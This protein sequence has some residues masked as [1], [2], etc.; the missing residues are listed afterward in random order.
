MEDFVCVSVRHKLARVKSNATYC[1]SLSIG[2]W[3]VS[4]FPARRVLLNHLA[5]NILSLFIYRV[6]Y[7][8]S[9]YYGNRKQNMEMLENGKRR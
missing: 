2:K 8:T 4:D 3:N 6:S 7:E 5:F 9:K 1:H